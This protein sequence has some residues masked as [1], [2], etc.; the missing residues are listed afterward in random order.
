MRVAHVLRKYNPAEWGGTE[1]AVQRLCDGLRAHK[2]ESVAFC[3]QL[4]SDVLDDPLT[5]AGHSVKRFNACVPVWGISEENRRALISIGGNL[6]SFDLLWDL[7]REPK[8][9][10]VHIHTHNRLGGIGLTVSRWRNIPL[11]AQIHGGALDLPAATREC[12]D[13]P[14]RGGVEWGK[15]FGAPLRSRRVLECADAI[16]TC[17][18][19]EARLLEKRYPRQRIIVQSHGVPAAEYEKDCRAAALQAFPGIA[20]RPVLLMA[21]RIDTVKNQ[22]WVVEQSAEIFRRHSN[23]LLVIAGSVTDP[24]YANAVNDSIRRLGLAQNVL[25]TGPL[26]SGDPRLI[27]LFQSAR[28]LLLPSLSETFG[29]VILEAW[30]CGAPVIS[31]RTSGALDLVTDGENGCLFDL[32]KPAEFHAAVDG[33]LSYPDAAAR[34]GQAGRWLVKASYDTVTLA[35][36]VKTIYEELIQEKR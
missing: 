25:L 22:N 32:A 15:L 17:N 23:A 34:L 27:G 21:G 30:A 20:G 12:L 8:I 5:R 10:L 11:V 4:E 35:R 29:L 2:V 7:W 14:R 36:R 31:S 24:P 28:A 33:M 13:A 19:T 16:I 1:T 3:P 26:P 6:L 18:R 9:D